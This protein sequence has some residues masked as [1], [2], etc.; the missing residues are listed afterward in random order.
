M[1]AISN[2]LYVA[3]LLA[4]FFDA[5]WAIQ[6]L[7]GDASQAQYQA[8]RLAR[9]E[10]EKYLGIMANSARDLPEDVRRQMPRVD[11]ESWM[12]LA[13]H[14]P[15]RDA[16]ARALVWTVIEAWLPPAGQELRRYRRQLPQLWRFE[17]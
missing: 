8:S 7:V 2:H 4:N 16:K 10:V 5:G 9:P 17:M 11:W 15:P 1:N 14:L 3:S 12:A 13:E 6:V